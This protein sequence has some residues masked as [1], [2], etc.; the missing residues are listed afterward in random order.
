MADGEARFGMV[1]SWFRTFGHGEREASGE[2]LPDEGEN[3]K[4]VG[5]AR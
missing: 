2:I 3:K 4:E 5:I 1:C